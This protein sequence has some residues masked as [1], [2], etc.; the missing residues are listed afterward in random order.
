[1]A[2]RDDIV[3]LYIGYFNRAPDPEGLN[4]WL[5]EIEEG[6]M[7]LAEIA[8]SFSVQPEATDLYPFLAFPNIVSPEAFVTQV[9]ENLFNRAPDDEG[10][11]Y[12]VGEL[13]GGAPVGEAIVN[14]ISGAQNTDAGQDLTTLENKIDA[15]DDFTTAFATAG[16]D[17]FTTDADGNMV[18]LD[19]PLAAAR[20]VISEVTDDPDTVDDANQKT[21]DFINGT[22]GSDGNVFFLGTGGIDP[23][24]GE[25]FTRDNLVGTSGDDTFLAE[26]GDLITGDRIEGVNGLDELIVVED[27]DAFSDEISPVTN[28]VE[29]FVVTMQD[30]DGG[31]FSDN[32]IQ[33]VDVNY[34]AGRMVGV[35]RWENFDSRADLVIEDARDDTPEDGTFT[36]DITVAMVSTDP[37]NVDYAVYFDDPVNTGQN[38]DVVFVRA[39]DQ[40]NSDVFS[41][42]AVS[43]TADTGSLE[44]ALLS[45]FKFFYNGVEQRVSLQDEFV[46]IVEGVPQ[47]KPDSPLLVGEGATYEEL[48]KAVEIAIENQLSEDISSDLVVDFEG[49][50]QAVVGTNNDEQGNEEFVFGPQIAIRSESG[51]ELAEVTFAGIEVIGF[52]ETDTDVFGSISSEQDFVEDCIRID[53]VLDDVGKSSAGG[54]LVIGAMSTGTQDGDPRKSDSIGIQCFDIY[55]DRESN[56]QTINST[57]N[58]LEEVTIMSRDNDTARGD[59]NSIAGRDDLQSG[60]LIVRGK[61]PEDD[62]ATSSEIGRRGDDNGPF[63]GMNAQHNI[64]GFSDVRVINATA[65]N[66]AVDLT[67]ELTDEIVEKYLDLQDTDQDQSTDDVTFDYDLTSNDDEFLLNMSSNALTDA[68]TGSREDFV[69]DI[70]GGGGD[71]WITTNVGES[72]KVIDNQGQD[73]F[74]MSHQA[75]D[76]ASGL[77]SSAVDV[78]EDDVPDWYENHAGQDGADT[79]KFDVAGGAGDDTI[80]TYGYGDYR[81]DGGSGDDTIYAD[82]SGVSWLLSAANLPAPLINS[83]IDRPVTAQDDIANNIRGDHYQID[84]AINAVWT[85][86]DDNGDNDLVE[87]IQGQTNDNLFTNLSSAQADDDWYVTLEFVDDGADDSTAYYADVELDLDTGDNISESEIIQAIKDIQQNDSFL[88]AVLEVQDGPGN[89]LLVWSKIDGD[90][91]IDDLDVALERRDGDTGSVVNTFDAFEDDE[92]DFQQF[93]GEST[94]LTNSKIIGGTGNDNIVMSSSQAVFDADDASPD[95]LTAEQTIFLGDSAGTDTVIHFDTTGLSDGASVTGTDA[96]DDIFRITSFGSD[97]DWDTYNGLVAPGG[98]GGNNEIDLWT[99]VTVADAEEQYSGLAAGQKAIAIVFD[100]S[101]GANNIGSFFYMAGNGGG[102]D[103]DATLVAQVELIGTQWESLGEDNFFLS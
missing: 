98:A 10:L 12:W 59:S 71:D 47:L 34:D 66:G 84:Y 7:T 2:T 19:G 5:G 102:A 27:S 73:W 64:Y 11:A 16:L 32:N 56:L 1:M 21:E 87:D 77:V 31:G 4:Y 51:A 103:A 72:F 52:G 37:G 45:E 13:E 25:F 18:P 83:V 82:N 86:N 39:I 46:E 28:G 76:V 70:N 22:G 68:G 62:I 89:S 3:S 41:A 30:R 94:A 92:F 80:W 75:G 43:T 35:D 23:D 65:L 91:T 6:T 48:R 49:T 99:G 24:T 81:I 57:N 20:E 58:S 69:L 90:F 54:D 67:A 55:V 74:G 8:Q 38:D 15:A 61:T 78:D 33:G 14:I 29:H 60:D 95:E 26:P 96:L 93:G 53:V 50:F 63:P 36:A 101:E 97:G 17:F 88:D 100:D 42:A 40:D 9:F 44:S 85:F 79:S